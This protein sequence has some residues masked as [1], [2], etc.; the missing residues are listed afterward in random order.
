MP[1][2]NSL[3]IVTIPYKSYYHMDPKL[4]YVIGEINMLFN[5]LVQKVLFPYEQGKE[6][7][8]KSYILNIS[9]NALSI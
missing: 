8:I 1:V 7:T 6:F 5:F 9:P 2:I 3:P 4:E